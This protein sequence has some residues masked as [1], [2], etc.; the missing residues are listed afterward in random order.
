MIIY[1]DIIYML[2]TVMNVLMLK[3]HSYFL[4]FKVGWKR[5]ILGAALGGFLSI[6]AIIFKSSIILDAGATL[7][8]LR[9]VYGRS[10]TPELIRRFF[11][12]L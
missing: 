4:S 9:L 12:F 5:L 2:C 3:L 6:K 7:L 1:I 11:I 10:T 8:I